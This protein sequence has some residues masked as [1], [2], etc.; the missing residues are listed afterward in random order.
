MNFNFRSATIPIARTCLERN[1][2]VDKRVT[3]FVVPIGTTVNMNG[4]AIQFG[5]IAI[6]IINNQHGRVLDFGSL[7]SLTMVSTYSESY[8]LIHFWS[9]LFTTNH[10]YALILEAIELNINI[11]FIY[12]YIFLLFFLYYFCNYIFYKIPLIGHF[13]LLV[14]SSNKWRSEAIQLISLICV[15]RCRSL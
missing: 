1:Q 7:V 8:V 10:L 14:I 12:L 13:M 3:G 4:A 5:V 6:Y 11:V 2:K 9:I 15:Y